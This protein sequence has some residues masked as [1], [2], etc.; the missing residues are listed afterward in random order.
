[1]KSN[2]SFILFTHNEEKRISYVLRN[3][4]N[5]GDIYILDGG[6]TDKTKEISESFGAKF[7]TR[8]D[9][10][11]PNV[12]TQK[13]LDFI[14]SII[15]TDWVYWGYVDNIIPKKLMEKMVEISNQ[16]KFKLVNLPLYTYLWGNTKNYIQKSYGPFLFHKDYIDLNE[17]Y[18]H[19]F[20]KF[21]GTEDQKLFL[22][23]KESLAVKHFS[24]YN[25]NKF[26]A[27]HMKY[28]DAEA[29]EKYQRG[30]KFSLIKTIAAMIRYIFIYGRQGYKSGILG[31]LIVLNYA[32]FR[33]ITYT[34]LYEIENNINLETIEDNYSKVKEE[35][36]KDFK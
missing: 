35:I 25:I 32:F 29:N 5:Y 9:N 34:K 33:L 11:K 13:N 14:K 7:F 19:G 22:E 12:E 27:G 15:K 16:D 26:V 24:T 4:V 18:I 3:F 23:S 31:I 20:G 2:I 28:G 21:L 6:S 30:E 8:P 17:N 10:S 36:L 1:M